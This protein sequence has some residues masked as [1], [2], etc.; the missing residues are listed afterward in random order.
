[1]NQK[2]KKLEKTLCD[3]VDGLMED[4][5]YSKSF[6]EKRKLCAEI[7]S[8]LNVLE[9]LYDIMAEDEDE[10]EYEEPVSER[11]LKP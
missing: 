4:K 11:G 5:K 7:R 10:E 9:D 8:M 2:L 6:A 1:M 3:R